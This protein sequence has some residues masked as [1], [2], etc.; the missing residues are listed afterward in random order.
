MMA[1]LRYLKT[2]KDGLLG[3][4]AN[5]ICTIPDYRASQLMFVPFHRREIQ[6]MV[7]VVAI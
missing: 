3:S 2:P 4:L 7:M 5:E 1:L 6:V